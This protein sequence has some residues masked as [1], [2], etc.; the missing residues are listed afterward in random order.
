[1]NRII[2]A[3]IGFILLVSR[4]SQLGA[5]SMAEFF[6]NYN[7]SS[8]VTVDHSPWDHLLT[9]HLNSA[10]PSG[11]S[12]FNYKAVGAK[13]REI[14]TSY[15]RTLEETNIFALDRDE[16]MAYWI[17]FYNALT[18][19]VV[20]DHYPV[21]SIRK[22]SLP[23][24]RRGPWKAKLVTV[25]GKVLS[26]DDIEHGI[27][28]PIWRDPRIH[29]VVNCASLG[30]PNLADRAYTAFD[31]ET[32]LDRA[33]KD[34]INHPRGVDS[35]GSLLVLSSIYKWYAEDFGEGKDGLYSHL[36]EYADPKTAKMIRSAKHGLR[37]FYDWK[38]NEP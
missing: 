36:L 14:L 37:Y 35:K 1:M 2:T 29:Y 17:N 33:A 6:A 4:L 3:F 24:S 32:M 26:L 7:P 34:Y 21:D 16:Q 5:E 12:R 11:I 31:L 8:K 22:I 25:S 23:G 18:V 27:L 10:H 20:L 9:E 38:L 13:D 28:R 15:L 19:R 30:C